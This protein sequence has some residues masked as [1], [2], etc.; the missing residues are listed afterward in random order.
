[1]DNFLSLVDKYTVTV[2]KI[3]R[4][5]AQG[6]GSA[7][8]IRNRF[9][10]KI[11]EAILGNTSVNLHLDFIYGYVVDKQ[12]IPLDGQQRLTTLFLLHWFAANKI[13]AED[14]TKKTIKSQLL[15][16]TYDTRLSSLRFCNE[17]VNHVLI[18]KENQLISKTIMNQSWFMRVWENDPTVKSMLVMLDAINE[19]FSSTESLWQKLIDRK[20]TFKL[21]D[22][23]SDEF[24]LTD[25][26]Y[27]KMNSRGRPL[28]DF[29]NFKA[30]FSEIL[31]DETKEYSSKKIEFDFEGSIKKISFQEYFSLKM[32]GIWTDLFWKENYRIDNKIDVALYNY[33][34]NLSEILFYVDNLKSDVDDK[35]DYV[36]ST[37]ILNQIYSKEINVRILF[38]SLDYHADLMDVKEY[39]KKFFTLESSKEKIRLFSSETVD[40]F[41]KIINKNISILERILFYSISLYHLKS[42]ENDE[43]NEIEF[44]R[45]VRNVFINVRQV[46]A[47]NRINITPDLRIN[48]MNTYNKFIEKFTNNIF[49]VKSV[50]EAIEFDY[51]ANY[52]NRYIRIESQK[53]ALGAKKENWHLILDLENH[54]Y[55]QGNLEALNLNQNNISQKHKLITYVWKEDK[56]TKEYS[57]LISKSL[58]TKGDFSVVSHENSSL[59]DICFFGVKDYWQRILAPIDKKERENNSTIL[60]A[61]SEN[62]ATIDFNGDSHLVLNSIC[63]KYLQEIENVEIDK[64]WKYYFIKHQSILSSDLNLFSW[65]KNGFGLNAIGSASSQPLSAYHY[66]PYLKIINLTLNDE[67]VKLVNERF[68]ESSW[69]NIENK[70]YVRME[71]TR[72]VLGSINNFII[73]PNVFNKIETDFDVEKSVYLIKFDLKNDRI[74]EGIDLVK[75]LQRNLE[76][77]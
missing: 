35:S 34:D 49:E 47:K 40:L 13:S 22:I 54:I 76:I 25:E 31:K 41:E 48:R 67:K 18:Q 55:L 14:F 9:L 15:K 32:D 61:F 72:W 38:N 44:I 36:F 59:G 28:T 20:I 63:E 62:F 7:T 39:Y 3:Q 42:Q 73:S 46:N 26:L 66:N 8:V 45:V 52:I 70:L 24:K 69:L 57:S 50:Q 2:P 6:R 53:S 29:E 68:S 5:Y 60:G 23:K 77:S 21:I 30:E 75:L 12:F 64:D 51:D 19:K 27:I 17:L 11:E 43:Q 4:D 65:K 58:L 74:I 10:D 1:M 37:E 33:F 71:D 56:I 16:F